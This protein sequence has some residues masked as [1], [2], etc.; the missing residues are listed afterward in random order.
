GRF[1]GEIICDDWDKIAGYFKTFCGRRFA[2]NLYTLVDEECVRDELAA[3]GIADA[4][5]ERGEIR[6]CTAGTT[7]CD[8]PEE[9]TLRELRWEDYPLIEKHYAGRESWKHRLV[10]LKQELY[11]RDVCGNEEE[12]VFC[13]GL[14]RGERMIGFAEGRL[15]RTHGFLVN[16]EIAVM[17]DP[18]HRREDV[19]RYVFSVITAE[20]LARGALP[21]D[22]LHTAASGQNCEQGQFD[23]AQFGYRTVSYLYRIRRNGE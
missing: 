17:P 1:E 20:A 16:N 23:S 21:V 5:I 7:V 10:H 12:S 14:F 9:T 6:A 22:T 18:E 8:P 13:F 15:Q 3:R 2:L 11:R 19:Y 4:E